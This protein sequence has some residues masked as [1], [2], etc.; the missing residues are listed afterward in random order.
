MRHRPRCIV[1]VG[2][3]RCH[4]SAAK[5]MGN[6]YACCSHGRMTLAVLTD[7]LSESSRRMLARRRW[8]TAREG[9]RLIDRLHRKDAA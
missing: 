7:W 5:R 3:H 9:Q 8:D 1:L 2:Y 4:R 6:L